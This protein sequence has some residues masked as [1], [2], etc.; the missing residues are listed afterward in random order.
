MPTTP[1]WIAGKPATGVDVLDVLSPHTGQ[2]AGSTTYADAEQVEAAVAAADAVRAEFAASPAH[3]RA[4]AL[5]HVS[6]RLAEPAEE[7]ALSSRPSAAS[8]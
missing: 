1:F 5:D 8:R 4:A 2:S 3:V 7:V 6:R